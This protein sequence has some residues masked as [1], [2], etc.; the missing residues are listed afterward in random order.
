MPLRKLSIRESAP[1]CP[2]PKLCAC[3][4][5]PPNTFFLLRRLTAPA[6]APKNNGHMKWLELLHGRAP[7]MIWWGVY[8]GFN[9]EK[10]KRKGRPGTPTFESTDREGKSETNRPSWD[11]EH[12]IPALRVAPRKPTRWWGADRRRKDRS[13]WRVDV[14]CVHRYTRDAS[15]A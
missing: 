1:G 15:T 7:E 6:S 8:V 13:L 11:E 5:L 2:L 12:K 4:Q 3:G 10:E 9:E 14:F